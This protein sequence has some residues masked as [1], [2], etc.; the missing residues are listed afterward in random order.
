MPTARE[1]KL[2][3]WTHSV[4]DWAVDRGYIT[5]PWSPCD[6]ILVRMEAYFKA[7]IDPIDAADAVFGPKH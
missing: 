6:V 7:D 4:F 1:E 2:H 5:P 3:A